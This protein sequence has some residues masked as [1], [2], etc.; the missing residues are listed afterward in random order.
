[1]PD[2]NNAL[3]AMQKAMVTAGEHAEGLSTLQRLREC[4]RECLR[5]TDRRRMFLGIGAAGLTILT[6]ANFW[7][8][9]RTSFFEAAGVTNSCLVSLNLALIN[10]VCSGLDEECFAG[11]AGRVEVKEW[12]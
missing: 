11:K 8:N 10:F 9:Y 2:I 4:L 7:F 6:G 3:A 12:A 1:M 5:G